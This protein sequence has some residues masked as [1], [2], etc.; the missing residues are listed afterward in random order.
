MWASRSDGFMA[1]PG[2]VTATRPR[3]PGRGPCP[4]PCRGVRLRGEKPELS[5]PWDTGPVPER[6]ARALTC[7]ARARTRFRIE[8][9]LAQLSSGRCS[10]A[11][12]THSTRRGTPGA[13]LAGRPTRGQLEFRQGLGGPSSTG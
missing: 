1:C 4:R 9:R 8:P 13:D 2:D 11:S 6:K 10:R 7:E 3:A 5:L 12:I